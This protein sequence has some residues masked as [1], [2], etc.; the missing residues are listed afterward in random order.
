MEL[1]IGGKVMRHRV[2]HL[3]LLT[4]VRVAPRATQK[5]A[6]NV[7]Q[8]VT[9]IVIQKATRTR[10]RSP[11]YERK[12]DIALITIPYFKTRTMSHANLLQD[13]YREYIQSCNAK[14]T[15]D[16][17]IECF[18]EL[19]EVVNSQEEERVMLF[20]RLI[21]ILLQSA[22]PYKY[23]QD[24]TQPRYS[25]MKLAETLLLKMYDVYKELEPQTGCAAEVEQLGTHI[26]K[27]AS[28]SCTI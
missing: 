23:F 21:V 22:G 19:I 12:I 2:G 9:R 28:C 24:E 25:R 1:E 14:T 13:Y 15:R 8:K 5:V 17:I 26:R 11:M 7:A 6:Q 10:V 3:I 27:L 4:R 20:A 16:Y 18:K